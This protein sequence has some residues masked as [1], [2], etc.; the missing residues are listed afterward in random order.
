MLKNMINFL[1]S[2]MQPMKIYCVIF[3]WFI[4]YN[5]VLGYFSYFYKAYAH[6]REWSSSSND[7]SLIISCMLCVS[8]L[9]S[10]SSSFRVWW[11]DFRF[12]YDKSFPEKLMC[13][14]PASKRC[15]P[16]N[17][18]PASFKSWPSPCPA[19]PPPPTNY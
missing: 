1:I 13:E 7:C 10:W 9:P 5:G 15:A 14:L 19:A 3:I 6:W 11:N 2:F 12:F 18:T 16:P 17:E 8:I 4:Y